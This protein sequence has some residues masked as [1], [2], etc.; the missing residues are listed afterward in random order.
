MEKWSSKGH[1]HWSIISSPNGDVVR[2]TLD[3]LTK[4]MTFKF[5]LSL[6]FSP[7]PFSFSFLFSLFSFLFSLTS[8]Q[9]QNQCERN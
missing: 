7:F 1:G 3:E 5:E 4:E 2:V 6:F 9:D 8:F